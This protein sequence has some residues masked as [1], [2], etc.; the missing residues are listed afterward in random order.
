MRPPRHT[1]TLRL[2]E[3]KLESTEGPATETARTLRALY[4]LDSDDETVLHVASQLPAIHLGGCV[5]IWPLIEPAPQPEHH[6][7]EE[8]ESEPR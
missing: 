4:L 7:R 3:G 2:V 6:H 1:R 8:P 5:E